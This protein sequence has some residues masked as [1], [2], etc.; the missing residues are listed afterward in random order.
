MCVSSDMPQNIRVGRLEKSFFYFLFFF[1][2]VI[3]KLFFQQILLLHVLHPISASHDKS[4]GIHWL[5]TPG[6]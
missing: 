2:E 3:A 4:L 5:T 6:L 1:K